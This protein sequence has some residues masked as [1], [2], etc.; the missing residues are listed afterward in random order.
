MQ[1]YGERNLL[2]SKPSHPRGQ[3]SVGEHRDDTVRDRDRHVPDG[4]GEGVTYYICPIC[5]GLTMP[6]KGG[7]HLRYCPCCGRVHDIDD[8]ETREV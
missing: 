2:A 6:S 8:C 7:R 1:I 5:S 4:E 3:V